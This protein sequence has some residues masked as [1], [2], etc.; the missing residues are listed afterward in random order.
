M[1][2]KEQKLREFLECFTKDEL[3]F[4]GNSTGLFIYIHNGGNKASLDIMGK[5]IALLEDVEFKL[6][7][8]E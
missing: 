8:D 5:K 4:E 2:M 7:G 3:Q 1:N 6:K